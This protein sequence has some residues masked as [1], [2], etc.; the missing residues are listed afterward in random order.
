MELKFNHFIELELVLLV[1]PELT[2]SKC[3]FFFSH[4]IKGMGGIADM[5]DSSWLQPTLATL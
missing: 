1:F 4:R 2:W 3:I 5:R